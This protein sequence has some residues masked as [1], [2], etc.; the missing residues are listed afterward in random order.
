MIQA[1][2]SVVLIHPDN[3]RQVI[4]AHDWTAVEAVKLFVERTESQRVE[5]LSLLGAKD[6]PRTIAVEVRR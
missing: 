3:T 5:R 2:W 1:L 4:E 6:V